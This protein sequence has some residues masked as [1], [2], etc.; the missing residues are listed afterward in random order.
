[1]RT[2]RWGFILLQCLW[3]NVVVPGHTR[4]AMAMP[5]SKSVGVT[6]QASEGCCGAK[7]TKSQGTPVDLGRCA[8]CHYAVG[9]TLPP[10]FSFDH[11]P[12][13]LVG[14]A[15]VIQAELPFVALVTTTLFG[16][17]PPVM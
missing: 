15:P 7:R 2:L 13:G 9:L 5:G 12:A 11:R 8:V 14:V 4:G 6:V 10:V 3:L 16:R 17:G 1:M